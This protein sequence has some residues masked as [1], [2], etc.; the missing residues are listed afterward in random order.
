MKRCLLIVILWISILDTFPQAFISH[1][2]YKY[3]ITKDVLTSVSTAFGSSIAPPLIEIN[4][5]DNP[6]KYI[7]AYIPGSE[8]LIIIDEEVYDLTVTFGPDSLNALAGI[9]SH[10]L[11]HHYQR[12]NFCSD[13]AFILGTEN[14]LAARITSI[15]KEIK[16]KNE[17]EADYY[18]MFYGYVAGYNT[19]NMFPAILDKIYSH[20]KLPDK[21]AG[22]PSKSERK[23]IATASAKKLDEWI[24]IF[25][26]GELLFSLKKYDDAFECFN[27]LSQV[28]PSREII[29]NAG[30]IKLSAALELLSNDQYP[31]II[32]VEFDAG[33]RLKRGNTRDTGNDEFKINSL[34]QNAISFFEKA[35]QIDPGYINSQ[36]NLACAYIVLKNYNLAIGISDK[37]L[38]GTTTPNDLRSLSRIYTVRGLAY[39]YLG[40]GNKAREDIVKAKSLDNNE[41]TSYN[42]L[43][44][45]KAQQGPIDQIYD[46]L[47]SLFKSEER[48]PEQDVSSVSMNE[49]IG[50]EQA[51]LLTIQKDG[52]SI[53]IQNDDEN[54]SIRYSNR[55]SYTEMAISS[56]VVHL[57]TIYTQFGYTGKTARNLGLYDPESAVLKAYGNPSYSIEAMAGSYLIYKKLKIVFYMSQAKKINKWWIYQVN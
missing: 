36:I 46:K 22:Y 7:A 14:S 37:L 20:Y 23:D 15:D 24:R 56:D 39:Y 57:N 27:K 53:N 9:I 40:E 29:N 10:E 18:G 3:R 4:N 11:A 44:L 35:N 31:F 34:T 41:M 25:D 33:T 32:P 5:I 12:H 6:Q 52:L 51:N 55:F 54:I 50:Q 49:K 48:T 28:F 38:K 47:F 19:F 45:E 16:E 17:A 30:V 21:I 43:L 13:F 8:N 26:A 42:S 2:N 1:S